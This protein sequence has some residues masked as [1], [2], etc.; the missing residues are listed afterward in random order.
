LHFSKYK[1]KKKLILDIKASWDKN[2]MEE[3][4]VEILSTKK[5]DT[6]YLLNLLESVKNNKKEFNKFV[7]KIQEYKTNYGCDNFINDLT[8]RYCTYLN[9]QMS[10]QFQKEEKINLEKEN[11]KVCI[12][13]ERRNA[14]EGLRNY[15]NQG[16]GQRKVAFNR[17]F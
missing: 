16:Y 17:S 3:N 6:E 11:K 8:Y 13:Q 4:N 10:E 5:R 7:K 14:K 12:R 15:V 9:K 1:F 2:I